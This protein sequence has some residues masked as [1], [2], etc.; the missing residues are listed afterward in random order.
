MDCATPAEPAEG[1]PS[2]SRPVV[3]R[4][5]PRATLARRWRPADV[6]W[7]VEYGYLLAVAGLVSLLAFLFF[8]LDVDLDALRRWGYFGIFLIALIGSASVALPLPG[9]A[10]VVGASQVV[11]DVL[12]IPF[13][14]LVGVTA[15]AGE[16][17][18]E[19]T[20]YLAGMG[21]KAVIERRPAYR[22]LERWMNRRGAASLFLLSLI[23]NPFFDIAGMLAGAV[24]MPLLHF[25]LVVFLGK[26]IK[27]AVLA[28]A[29]AASLG[30]LI[31][32]FD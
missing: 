16:T 5:A 14:L 13:W 9:T 6:R 18:G 26:A 20:G 7:R 21:G 29:G 12:G 27:N 10:L 24:R 31:G 4:P 1:A 19:L 30:A 25:L 15:A 11:N 22:H 3:G 2:A 23:P 8:F 17:L 28:L 32:A